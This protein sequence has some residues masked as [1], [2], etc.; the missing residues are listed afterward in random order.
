MP[1]GVSYPQGNICK[2]EKFIGKANLLSETAA[3]TSDE[4]F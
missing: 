3:A 2:K 1:S 4:T